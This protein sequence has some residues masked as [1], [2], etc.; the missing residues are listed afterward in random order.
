ML[1]NMR[2]AVPVEARELYFPEIISLVDTKM[3]GRVNFAKIAFLP[4]NL[5]GGFNFKSLS[6]KLY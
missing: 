6:N 4:T 2:D 3:K 5:C 1:V